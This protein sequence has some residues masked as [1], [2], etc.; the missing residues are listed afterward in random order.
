LLSWR[1]KKIGRVHIYG[2]PHILHPERLTLGDGTTINFGV[3]IGARGGVTIGRN[4]RLSTYAVI[5]TAFLDPTVATRTKHHAKPIIIEDGVWIASRATVLAG[6]TVGRNSVVA[7]G[8]VVTRDV[9]P[10]S[11]AIGVPAKC[12]PLRL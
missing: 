4:V 12:K 8:A 9:P 6:V 11:I 3:H 1:V 7:A 5:E 10:C 2:W